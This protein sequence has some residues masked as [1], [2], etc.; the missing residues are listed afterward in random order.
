[1][2]ILDHPSYLLLFF[3]IIPVFYYRHIWKKRGGNI[4]LAFGTW[5]GPGFNSKRIF[6][7][8][9]YVLSLVFFWTGITLFIFALAGP[10]TV[11]RERVYM[12]RGIDMMIV[13][14]ESPSMAAKDFPGNRFETAK[15][16]IREFVSRRNNDPIGLVSFGKDA[17]LR[18][19]PTLDYKALLD[20]LGELIIMDLG[21]GTAIGMGISV[22]ALH[23]RDSSAAE[24]VIILLTD[25]KNNT[26]EILPET[27]AKISDQLG[28]RIYA[29]GIGSESE[30]PIEVV[31]PKTGAIYRGTVEKGFNEELL[32][33]I[34]EIS[35]GA[36]FR[37][38][39]SGT[40]QF[41][42]QAIDS[43][44]T[45]E[46][47]VRLVVHSESHHRIFIFIGFILILSDYLI[48]KL[49]LREVL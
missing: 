2:L 38:S 23:L 20:R 22:A 4:S 24:K 29:V 30:V 5:N 40:L 48:R 32:L 26:G 1:M 11:R 17:A 21:D 46:N 28:I 47:R 15:D 25:G 34:A 44:E 31:N 36:Y 39:D 9:V 8:L 10:V 27:A 18:M 16:V 45:T 3:I 19:P 14:D 37:A 6:S 42:F 7:K 12:S 13:L 33:Q 43:I 41:I 49:L 35:Q